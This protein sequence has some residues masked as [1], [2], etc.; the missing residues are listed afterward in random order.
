ML[1]EGRGGG[2]GGWVLGVQLLRHVGQ[3][4]V[5]VCFVCVTR[6]SRSNRPS[7]SHPTHTHTCTMYHHPHAGS[8][9]GKLL[10]DL[11]KAFQ[12]TDADAFADALYNYN[13]ISAL[14]GWKVSVL[15]KAKDHLGG[16]GGGGGEG[17]EAGLV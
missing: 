6:L 3:S 12:N 9:E 4:L 10:S 2:G 1:G 16:G 13:Q 11:V 15:K 14:D 5:C 17:D 7:F 8:R